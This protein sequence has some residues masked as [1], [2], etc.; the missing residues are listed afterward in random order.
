M[1][2]IALVFFPL[3]VHIS[4]SFSVFFCI[5]TVVVFAVIP[6]LILA[7]FDALKRI[8]STLAYLAYSFQPLTMNAQHTYNLQHTGT[9]TTFQT[10]NK[11]KYRKINKHKETQNAKKL[12]GMA[13]SQRHGRRKTKVAT[14]KLT[15]VTSTN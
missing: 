2:S 8:H 4:L 14:D 15:E 3:F 7:L 5:V 13:R 9:I 11:V 1:A 12:Q 10:W 6:Y